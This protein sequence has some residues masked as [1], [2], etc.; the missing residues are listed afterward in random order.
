MI[1]AKLCPLPQNCDVFLLSI[2]S[3][4]ESVVTGR[5]NVAIVR[6]EIGSARAVQIDGN[7]TE[8]NPRPYCRW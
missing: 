3:L 7:I 6:V 2:N 4:G 5:N 8:G 1:P